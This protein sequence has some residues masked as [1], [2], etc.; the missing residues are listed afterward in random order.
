MKRMFLEKFF[1][2]SKTK[3][4]KK[5]TYGIRQ[6]SGETL[7][8]YKERS[9]KLCA[10][11][12]HHHI[13]EQLLIKYFYEGIMLMDKNMMDVASGNTQQF[14]IRGSVAS[15]VVN[16]VVGANNQRLENKITKLTSLI[17]Q[18]HH[19]SPPAR[20]CD[21]CACTKHPTDACLTLQEIG[22]NSAE[23]VAMMGGQQ[24]RQ[25]HD[26][27]LNLRYGSHPI[28]TTISIQTTTTYSSYTISLEDFLKYIL[29]PQANVSVLTLRSDKELPHQQATSK[30]AKRKATQSIIN[31]LDTNVVVQQKNST[32][33]IPLSFPSRSVQARKFEIDEELLQAFIMIPKY[34]KFL[35]ELCTNKK[36][37]LKGDVE[38]G[39]NVSALIRASKFLL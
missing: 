34:A 5:V 13:N 33:T 29:S 36:K 17:R 32:R 28:T 23:V 39:R 4:I 7:Y 15:S 31:D 12:P 19:T 14:G 20:V 16:E 18:L 6:R 10:T 27:Y 25:L 2:T 37:K 21:I 24:Y 8:K 1:P 38:I 11:C 9:N 3:S 22:P 35:K 30:T 26:Q